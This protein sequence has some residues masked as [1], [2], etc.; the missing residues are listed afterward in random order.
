MQ[1]TNIVRAVPSLG[2]QQQSSTFFGPLLKVQ[3]KLLQSG[4]TIAYVV[5]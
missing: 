1:S 2:P 4:A 5:L 3:L